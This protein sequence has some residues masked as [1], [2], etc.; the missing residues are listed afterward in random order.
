MGADGGHYWP[1]FETTSYQGVDLPWRDRLAL[2]PG[3]IRRGVAGLIARLSCLVAGGHDHRIETRYGEP[4]A[5]FLSSADRQV[6]E[7]CGVCYR[8]TPWR[9]Q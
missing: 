1:V 5:W 6:R 2:L 7:V 4:G 8:T 3:D 9:T